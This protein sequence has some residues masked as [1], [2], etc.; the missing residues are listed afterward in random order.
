MFK[1]N[2]RKPSKKKLNNEHK[3]QIKKII[4]YNINLS[5]RLDFF[6]VISSF[7][8]QR[9]PFIVILYLYSIIIFV[10]SLK[11]T[12]FSLKKRMNNKIKN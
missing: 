9:V 4:F 2:M 12:L 8:E 10:G 6:E 7:L 5:T 1:G 3:L 11:K